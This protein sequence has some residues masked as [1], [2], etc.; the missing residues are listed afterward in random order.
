[1]KISKK[2]YQNRFLIK[3][4]KQNKSATIQKSEEKNC[5]AESSYAGEN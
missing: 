4:H 2:S 3:E 5:L 1:V